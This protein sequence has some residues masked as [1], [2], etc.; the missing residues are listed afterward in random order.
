MGI[1]LPVEGWVFNS[2]LYGPWGWDRSTRWVPPW[3][4]GGSSSGSLCGFSLGAAIV[5]MFIC[6]TMEL[7]VRWYVCVTLP[8]IG[9][10]W[11]GDWVSVC[12]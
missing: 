8:F 3:V 4:P 10:G 1:P 9:L 2:Q 7:Q 5:N 12:V 11:G 6:I